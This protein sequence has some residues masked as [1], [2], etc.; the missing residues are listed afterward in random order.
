MGK[1]VFN[2]KGMMRDLDPAKTS[3][4]YAYE[5]RNLRIT[6]QEDS[7]FMTLTTELGNKRVTLVTPG[8]TTPATVTGVVVGY[9]VLNNYIVLFCV[10]ESN[11]TYINRLEPISNDTM[12]VSDV[13]HGDI[14]MLDSNPIE[15][16]GMY[17]REDVQN[18][19]WIDGVNQPRVIN[20]AK[21]YRNVDASF[22]DFNPVMALNEEV[23]ITKTNL[24]GAF[25]A[26][27]VQYFLTY[28]NK[29]GQQTP[30]FYQSPIYY[31]SYEGRGASPEETVDN[32][33]NISVANVDD[34]FDFVRIY[35][36]VRS[37][38]NGTP[39]CK[40]VADINIAESSS[41]FSTIQTFSCATG[42]NTT[43]TT[44][45]GDYSY[46]LMKGSS[47]SSGTLVDINNTYH[48]T[49][50]SSTGHNIIYRIPSD[51]Y[52]VLCTTNGKARVLKAPTHE[53]ILLTVYEHSINATIRDSQMSIWGN[54]NGL[55]YSISTS[56]SLGITFTDNNLTGETVS[57][58]DIMFAGGTNIIPRTMDQ[59]DNTLFFGNYSTPPGMS[60]EDKDVIRQGCIISFTPSNKPVPK[61][62]L[63]GHY[64]YRNQLDMSAADIT[65][66]KGGETYTFGIILQD[67]RGRWT[68][69]IPIGKMTN[70]F[71]PREEDMNF[72]P[73]K[74]NIVFTPDAKEIIMQYKRVKVVTLQDISTVVCQG[75]LCPTVF[76]KKRDSNSPYC[77]SSWFFRDV[78][79]DGI[80]NHRPIALHNGNIP[81]GGTVYENS[82]EIQGAR[83]NS[84]AY[85][86]Y[87]STNYTDMDMFVDWNTLT[88]HSPEIEWGQNF[89]FNYNLRLV[90]YVPITF[91][92]T[93]MQVTWS[94]PA[95]NTALNNFQYT[96]MSHAAV[97][98]DAYELDLRTFSFYDAD[99]SGGSTTY[100][101]PL[102]PWQRNGSLNSDVDS[103]GNNNIAALSTKVMA[104][105][106][107]STKNMFF[108]SPGDKLSYAMT[109]LQIYQEDDNPVMIPADPLNYRYNGPKSYI[110]SVDTAL[111]PTT[112]YSTYKIVP[113][114]NTITTCYK[115]TND[116]IRMR[117]RSSKHGVFSL[118]CTQHEMPVLP[119]VGIKSEVPTSANDSYATFTCHQI[120]AEITS[121]TISESSSGEITVNSIPSAVAHLLS[122]DAVV[123]ITLSSPTT[124]NGGLWYV[125]SVDPTA[126]TATMHIVDV[127]F[128]KYKFYGYHKVISYNAAADNT[129]EEYYF[130]L[131]RNSSILYQIALRQ[132]GTTMEPTA[133]G[134]DHLESYDE[135]SSY[136]TVVI[137]TS[138]STDTL[139]QASI[140]ISSDYPYLYLAE[141][142]INNS[143]Q[144]SYEGRAWNV[145][146]TSQPTSQL[147][148]SNYSTIIADIGD[149][150]YQRYD[151]LKTYPYSL[152]DQNQIVEIF[153]FM[154][155]T[156]INIDGR[157]DN[158]RGLSDNINVIGANFNKL[159]TAYT[160]SDNFLTYS[161]LNA[162]DYHVHE[163]PNQI[164]WTKTKVYGS[165]IDAWTEIPATSTL[166]LNGS[167]GQITALKA[168]NNDLI[169]FQD[170]GIAKIMYNE[171]T[172]LTTE[173]GVP[174]E[175]ANS[176]KVE[177]SVYIS[178][179]V[180]CSN[181]H[182]VQDTQEGL[183][184]IDSNKKEFYKWSKGL[185]PLSKSK[186]FNTYFND[187][188]INYNKLK[189]FYD[190]KLKDVYV[191]VT[192]ETTGATV[193]E[194]LVYNEQVGEFTSF[195]DY[196]VNFMFPY[197]GEFYAVPKSGI[198]IWKQFSGNYL[199]YFNSYKGYSIE[200]ISAE[201]PLIDKTFFNVE[202]RADVLEGSITGVSQD[203][204][205]GNHASI[206]VPPFKTIRVW[207]EYQDTGTVNFTKVLR[208][209]ENLA[210]K[211]R[212][213]RGEIGRDTTKP[214]D[215][216]RSPWARIK[217]SGGN[218]AIKT[219]I[220]D[221][222]VSYV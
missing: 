117:Y 33:F 23:T 159:N 206:N 47:Y 142:Y 163:F 203:T 43:I 63:G 185:E 108:T 10:G 160:Q 83:V 137:D 199:T 214:L 219:V 61:G 20:I 169:C 120:V 59:K 170:M 95:Y 124:W 146:S 1:Q 176:G 133:G 151:C 172:T 12:V 99:E 32:A 42:T 138:T 84:L 148:S 173:Q 46:F 49:Y 197:K 85:Y 76:S 50:T 70:N 93:A 196:N 113:G 127:N 56:Q 73:I 18:V 44:I 19:Y 179:Q 69:V 55:A 122:K 65:T 193:N 15:T 132:Y 171:R 54:A 103:L 210:Q 194:C 7:T 89:N 25:P 4:N 135:L 29:R 192:K 114:S 115:A 38:Q 81:D 145:A 121:A 116:P 53:E 3:G 31:T 136:R 119:N 109:K 82:G 51:F 118:L 98:T 71:Y 45:S 152:E 177:G 41:V 96:G 168:W 184:F 187:S 215:R 174:V 22:F 139:I 39:I 36:V 72:Y 57:Y 28:F 207:N 5:I 2:F 216:I 48:V 66:F 149:T 218:E 125:T 162:S 188:A 213:W 195:F 107:G 88:L 128:L 221:V 129:Q 201:N 67:D 68:D 204:E 130:K 190:P 165:D 183:Y 198:T 14:G 167:L 144:A 143:S 60:Q 64:M 126:G 157:Y 220:H 178:T 104:S 90:G 52:L 175:I 30:V 186:G 112:A 97:N 74:A 209:G 100:R 111:I 212:I 191:S 101:Y 217:L 8:G 161:Y 158:L 62:S 6:A 180:G 147:E 75:V 156:R 16:L 155:E 78:E 26:G 105:L 123:K 166:A 91:G 106:R 80:Y 153:S 94:S 9:C 37:S 200:F 87:P 102:Y 11:I 34:N 202:S 181:K 150:Y 79:A 134:S 131:V 110:A 17:E 140:D 164:I 208:H 189:V 77:Q 58:S 27:T 13:F 86:N 222:A 141:L 92:S 211:F 35:S 24:S 154:C 40:K 182:T 205:T 21:T